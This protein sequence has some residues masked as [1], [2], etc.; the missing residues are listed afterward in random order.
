MSY[1]NYDHSKKSTTESCGFTDEQ[2]E[3]LQTRWIK[4]GMKIGEIPY[5]KMVENCENAFNKR[6]L[7]V[8]LINT[9]R[10]AD[11]LARFKGIPTEKNMPSIDDIIE[12]LQ[13]TSKN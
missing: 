1:S 11:Q 12:Q 10:K 3:S 8:L 5:S 13:Q 4:E 7:A 6:E 2:F 9:L